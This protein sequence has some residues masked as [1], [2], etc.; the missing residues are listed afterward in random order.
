MQIIKK[1]GIKYNGDFKLYDSVQEAIE[2]GVDPSTILV[3][4]DWI[5]I[6]KEYTGERPTTIIY[7][8]V[9]HILFDDGKVG[10]VYALNI[11]KRW[12][13]I[14]CVTGVY[15]LSSKTIVSYKTLANNVRGNPNRITKSRYNFVIDWLFNN[16]PIEVSAVKYLKH[17]LYYNNKYVRLRK[18]INLLD[19]TYRLRTTLFAYYILTLPWFDRLLNEHRLIKDRYMSL[20][21]AMER[22]GV[23]EAY[24]AQ[25]IKEKMEGDNPRERMNAFNKAVDILLLNERNANLKEKE[26]PSHLAKMLDEH[27]IEKQEK[28]VEKLNKAEE[29]NKGE[30]DEASIAQIY[31]KELDRL[32]QASEADSGYTESEA[33]FSASSQTEE[34][35]IIP[36]I[37][38]NL[39]GE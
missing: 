9:L 12:G 4:N 21:N 22:A 19:S 34:S 33:T 25:Y 1:R 11:A 32:L 26:L 3:R 13:I 37:V 2:H 10:E 24:L 38:P 6:C 7:N 35:E 23:T 20:V 28:T 30:S 31:S 8:P 14:R 29:L 16:V 15:S 5:K 18:S 27:P 17:D 36:I 39:P